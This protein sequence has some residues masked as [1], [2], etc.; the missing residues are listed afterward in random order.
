MLKEKLDELKVKIVYLKP[1]Y[2][3]DIADYTPKLLSD[4]E[5]ENHFDGDILTIDNGNAEIAYVK[6]SGKIWRVCYGWIPLWRMNSCWD[7]MSK[8]LKKGNKYFAI[9]MGDSDKDE[10]LGMNALI[11][12]GF[13]TETSEG[14]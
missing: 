4:E 5:I 9:P 6:I 3:D 11:A 10:V 7:C 2:W 14:F 8:E 1:Q 12:I 13:E